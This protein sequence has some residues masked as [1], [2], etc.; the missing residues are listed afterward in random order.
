MKES[1]KSIA[2]FV[3][4]LGESFGGTVFELPVVAADACFQKG[5]ADFSKGGAASFLRAMGIPGSFFD[6][7]PDTLKR[8]ILKSQKAVTGGKV[9][10]LYLLLVDDKVVTVGGQTSWGWKGPDEVLGFDLTKI[11]ASRI[12]YNRGQVRYT[13]LPTNAK[14]FMP[15][16]FFSVP[17]FYTSKVIIEMGLFKTVCTNGAVDRKGV[18]GISMSSKDTRLDVVRAVTGAMVDATNRLKG[19][20]EV[21]ASLRAQKFEPITA[22]DNL[23]EMLH[24]TQRIPKTLSIA[25]QQHVN[26][27]S[28]GEEV[29]TNS[30]TSVSTYYEMLDA[31]TFYAQR[32]PSIASQRK[33]E[34]GIWDWATEQAKEAGSELRKSV[35]VAKAMELL[36]PAPKVVEEI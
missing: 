31:L 27:L 3:K 7:Q 18:V 17:I 9:K 11:A 24:V 33:A 15:A 19:Y 22:R 34:A 10:N 23:L 4:P 2:D 16:S 5:E 13:T 32:L 30:P 29:D 28:E 35:S 6:H 20:S 21:V 8:D 1:P 25:V 26:L 12:D 14:E 36:K